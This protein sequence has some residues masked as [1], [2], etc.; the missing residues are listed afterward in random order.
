[1]GF[2]HRIFFLKKFWKKMFSF[3]TGHS[4]K[5][6]RKKPSK[7]WTFS[8]PFI[9]NSKINLIFKKY[10]SITKNHFLQCIYWMLKSFSRSSSSLIFFLLRGSWRTIY[11]QKIIFNTYFWIVMFD[12]FVYLICKCWD[13]WKCYKSI[14]IFERIKF[15]K[16]KFTGSPLIYYLLQK[17]T[18]WKHTYFTNIEQV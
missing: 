2:G 10:F 9:Q 14:P 3:H 13:L 11:F 7:S 8:K 17:Y 4:E 16:Y 15:I 6:I 5:N 18:I 12:E 1:M